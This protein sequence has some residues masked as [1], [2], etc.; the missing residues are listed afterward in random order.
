MSTTD[1]PISTLTVYCSA[2][3]RIDASYHD[4]TRRLGVLMGERKLD[5]VY[6]GGKIGLMGTLSKT[7]RE[8]GCTV[9]GI[10]TERLKELEQLDPDNHHNVV[11]RT[12]R[13][14]KALL[15]TRGDAMVILPGGFGTLE[16]FFEILVGRHLGEHDNP[17]AIL[18][19]R[20]HHEGEGRYYDPLLTMIDHIVDNHFASASI[21]ELYRVYDTPDALIAGLLG[22]ERPA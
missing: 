18:N 4:A 10:I 13:E 1:G 12:M 16:E 20:D 19:M 8:H 3:T 9:T 7:C 21:R 6:G 11:V 15:E 22:S 17:I 2:S 5:L 14:R